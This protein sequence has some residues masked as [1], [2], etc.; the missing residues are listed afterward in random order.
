MTPMLPTGPPFRPRELSEDE[1]QRRL[2]AG[3]ATATWRY[4]AEVTVDA[5][6]AG[7]RARLP[8]GVTVEPR[9]AGRC[10]VSA[11]SDSPQLLALYLGMLDADFHL[12]ATAAPELRDHLRTLAAR[13]TAAAE[14]AGT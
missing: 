6:A 7:I 12:G 4:R 1:V 9:G 8:A 5:P 11:G 10:V 3:L 2:S 14:D 13:Y